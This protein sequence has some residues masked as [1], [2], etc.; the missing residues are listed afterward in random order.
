MCLNLV[1]K[2]LQEFKKSKEGVVLNNHHT[3]SHIQGSW[4]DD[5]PYNDENEEPY[6]EEGSWEPVE[7]ENIILH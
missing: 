5:S 1:D 6:D 4:W 2:Y 7:E 3:S